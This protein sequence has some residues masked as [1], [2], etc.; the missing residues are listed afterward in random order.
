LQ[1]HSIRGQR[2]E[3]ID[4]K[5][6]KI[7]LFNIEFFIVFFWWFNNKRKLPFPGIGGP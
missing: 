6:K 5:A 4:I 1:S 7:A 3:A 2:P